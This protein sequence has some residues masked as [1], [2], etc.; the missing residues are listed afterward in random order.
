MGVWSL[1]FEVWEFFG[2]CNLYLGYFES[3]NLCPCVFVS[4]CLKIF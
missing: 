4:V 1:G 3:G 2:N